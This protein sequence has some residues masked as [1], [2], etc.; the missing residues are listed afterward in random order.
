MLRV[1]SPHA[2]AQLQAHGEWRAF[3]GTRHDGTNA[4]MLDLLA[5]SHARTAGALLPL[6]ESVSLALLRRL[7]AGARQH[8]ETLPDLALYTRLPFVM[9]QRS[10]VRIQPC[11]C[12]PPVARR[13]LRWRA[14][15]VF[16]HRE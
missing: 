7:C 8:N 3:A 6:D 10:R 4:A 13:R 12:P 11:V 14:G 1:G 15:A 2:A 16:L 9:G 5:W